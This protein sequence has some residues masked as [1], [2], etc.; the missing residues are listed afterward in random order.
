MTAMFFFVFFFF[1]S[2]SICL[3]IVTLKGQLMYQYKFSHYLP[4]SCSK[5]VC[6]HDLFLFFSVVFFAALFAY[7]NTT[8]VLL[9]KNLFYSNCK[10]ISESNVSL[11]NYDYGGFCLFVLILFQELSHHQLSYISW[12]IIM[13]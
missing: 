10:Q 13:E 8:T 3:T 11:E 7:S 9:Q 6:C 5:H 2:N 4:S 1:V 12:K